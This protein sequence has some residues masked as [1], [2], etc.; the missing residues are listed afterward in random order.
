[1][2][3]AGRRGF[4]LVEVIV[5]I[6]ILAIAFAAA[7]RSVGAGIDVDA[8]LQR[9]ILAGWVAENRLATHHAMSAWLPEGETSGETTMGG[10]R[11]IWRETVGATPNSQFRRI[12]LAISTPE[13]RELARMT[14][15][16]AGPGS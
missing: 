13:G 4:T 14:G 12:D 7:S 10:E 5:A 15:F 8:Q 3:T 16:L 6:A 1:M 11:F 2:S 9:R